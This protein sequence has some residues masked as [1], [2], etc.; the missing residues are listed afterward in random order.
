[1]IRGRTIVLLLPVTAC[2][3]EAEGDAQSAMIEE[4]NLYEWHRGSVIP[5]PPF[6]Y[7]AATA[8]AST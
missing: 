2:S 3:S 4:S 8:A 6:D 7:C 1:M 5:D